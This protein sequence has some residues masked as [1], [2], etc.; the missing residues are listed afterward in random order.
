MIGSSRTVWWIVCSAVVLAGMAVLALAVPVQM[1]RTGRVPAAA[2]ALAPSATSFGPEERIWIDTDAACGAGRRVDPDDCFAIALLFRSR[3]KQIAGISTIFGNA[4]LTVTDN[5]T[6]VLLQH[7]RS[8]EDHAVEVYEGAALPTNS[9]ASL[10]STPAS[11]ALQQALSEGPLIVVSL[12]PLTNIAA[13]LDSRPDLQ[14][15]VRALI[16]VMGHRPGHIFH[17]T[18]GRSGAILFGHGPI[19]RDFNFAQDEEAVARVVAMNVPLILVPYDAARN[20]IITD[21]DL[22]ELV[23][24]GGASQWVAERATRWLSFWKDDIGQAGFYPFD[25]AAAAYV[26]HP[27]LFQCADVDARATRDSTLWNSWLFSTRGLLIGPSRQNQRPNAER[28]QVIYCPETQPNLK[29]IL[30][31]GLVNVNQ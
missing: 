27:E 5:T 15:N 14:A 17:P 29:T 3:S 20:I 18:E 25:L 2:L 28:A 22:S 26:L 31:A 16:A 12:G 9:P 23:S 11:D 30:I 19:F 4:P 10:A 6:R 21:A 24:A 1:W 13:A 8:D 7:L